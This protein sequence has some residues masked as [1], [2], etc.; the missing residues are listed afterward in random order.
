MM[1]N[2]LNKRLVANPPSGIRRIGQI[3]KSIPGCIALTIGE[4]EL[5]TP[6]PIRE[7]AK[8]ALDAGR[9]HYAP[10]RGT[11]SLRRAIAAYETGR[12]LRCNEEQVLVTMGATGA[13]YAALTGILAPGDEVIILKPAF[14]LYESIALAAGARP[15]YLDLSSTGFQLT[16]SQLEEVYTPRTRAIVVNSP[17]NPTGTVLSASSLAAIAAFALCPAIS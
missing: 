1:L 4:P 11:A 16:L 6:V 10:N 13:L 17:C 2:Y 8:A 3:A 14:S 5:D 7:A 12:G 15:V 9:T